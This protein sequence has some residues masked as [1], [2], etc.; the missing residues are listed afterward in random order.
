MQ[1]NPGVWPLHC[2]IAWH[3]STGMFASMMERAEDIEKMSGEWKGEMER[4]CANWKAYTRNNV[5]DQV[6]SG[7]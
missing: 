6:D 4:V 5:V 2:H 3:L 7:V 1:D